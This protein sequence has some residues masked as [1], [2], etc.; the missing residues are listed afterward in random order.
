MFK[1]QVHTQ[2]LQDPK[3]KVCHVVTLSKCIL[4]KYQLFQI[5]I[6][7]LWSRVTYIWH[8]ISIICV[9]ICYIPAA[10]ML[11]TAGSLSW[12][13]VLIAVTRTWP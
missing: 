10:G 8:C 9:V 5:A 6:F 4:K 3:T 11:M 12:P 2:S 13:Q 7:L 1:Q